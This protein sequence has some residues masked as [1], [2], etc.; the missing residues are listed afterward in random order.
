MIARVP[1]WIDTDPT[2]LPGGHEVDDGFAIALAFRSPELR[3]V[4]VSS[5]FGNGDIDC[6][7]AS[8]EAVVAAFGPIDMPVHR[9]AATPGDLHATPAAQALVDAARRTEQP[10]L[11][12][13]A[14]GPLTNI[15]AALTL[16]PDIAE[17]IASIIWV[18]GRLPGQQFR[19]SVQQTEAFADLNFEQDVAAA[20]LVLAGTVPIAL[21]SWTVCSKVHLGHAEIARLAA[22]D[23]ACGILHGPA[24]DWLDLWRSQFGLDYFMPFDTLAVARASGIG[25]VSGFAGRA[26]IT[27]TEPP[28]LIASPA[29]IVPADARPIW[30]GTDV[31]D[32]FTETLMTRITT[33]TSQ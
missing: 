13:L 26:W 4:G 29:D 31:G 6:C 18:A 17:Q 2:V 19:A 20:R 22:A 3:V 21:T 23:A 33:P 14:L 30:F 1:V 9:G 32:S 5:I 27:P 12:I 7:H 16:A 11:T 28:T 24:H 15:A 8:A 25:S 10:G